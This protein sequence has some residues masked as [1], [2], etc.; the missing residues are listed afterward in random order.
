MQKFREY[1]LLFY[2]VYFL[3][4]LIGYFEF[5]I[6]NDTIEEAIEKV[7][8]ELHNSITPAVIKNEE[9]NF[10]WQWQTGLI[11][12]VWLQMESRLN[13]KDKLLSGDGRSKNII[14]D[15]NQ[16]LLQNIILCIINVFWCGLIFVCLLRHYQNYIFLEKLINIV[17]ILSVASSLFFIF[18]E[19]LPSTRINTWQKVDAPL[20]FLMDIVLVFMGLSSL[21]VKEAQ[22]IILKQ[23]S[24]L[25]T[26]E[27]IK[28]QDD[29]LRAFSVQ[30]HFSLFSLFRFLLHFLCIC[31]VA[32]FLANTFLLSS[33]MLQ[34][35][36]PRL[37]G[38]GLIFIV[39]LGV[40]YYSHA[41][42]KTIQAY[43][44]NQ[45][46]I[47]LRVGLSFW[48]YRLLCN[49]FIIAFT[50]IFLVSLIVVI[51]LI[52]SYNMKLLNIS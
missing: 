4:I 16:S 7:A 46:K 50:S 51:V 41:Y 32:V 9:E 19:H 30:S 6:S 42:R 13:L 2:L 52:A 10:S 17:L 25:F 14:K 40:I 47:C 11:E 21:L 33:Y 37:F 15:V 39:L 23:N 49:V 38:M 12:K 22:S 5:Y 43:D 45:E 8:K 35:S 20:R 27:K 36:F 28:T 1:I 48:I 44:A 29:F 24:S 31:G 26:K 18:A 3:S 34:L